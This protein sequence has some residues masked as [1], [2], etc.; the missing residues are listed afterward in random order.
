MPPSARGSS[1]KI[2]KAVAD[3]VAQVGKALRGDSDERPVL[4]SS[5]ADEAKAAPIRAGY[6]NRIV[7]AANA[8]VRKG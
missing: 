4:S 7:N 5:L 2:P 3:K 8:R 6:L 1:P